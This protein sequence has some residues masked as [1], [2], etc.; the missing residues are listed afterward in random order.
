METNHMNQIVHIA[1]FLKKGLWGL[2]FALFLTGC[3]S[4]KD[5]LYF[6][7][8]TPNNPLPIT[9]PKAAVILPGDILSIRITALDALALKP[10][11]QNVSSS[12]EVQDSRPDDQFIIAHD[13]TIVFPVIGSIR[14]GGYNTIEAGYIMKREL[15]KYILDPIVQVDIVNFK[16]SILGEVK[17]PGVYIIPE[18][19]VNIIEL[20]GMAGDLTIFG[21]RP[22]ISVIRIENGIK[23]HYTVDLTSDEVFYSKVF[24]L[25][26]ND[27]VYVRPNKAQ[28]NR[29]QVSPLLSTVISL[30]NLVAILI[31][32]FIR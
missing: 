28:R 32:Y 19:K 5:M 3:A 22:D 30:V 31:Y 29:S 27:I 2:L 12:G 21:K 10:F 18:A 7:N 23:K 13:S 26:K 24:Y 1:S 17:K 20:I 9:L 4:K 6:Y 25:Q 8:Y 14:L 16:V 11:N 15:S